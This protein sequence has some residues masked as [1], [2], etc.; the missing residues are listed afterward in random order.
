MICPDHKL[1][2]QIFYYFTICV[3]LHSTFLYFFNLPISQCTTLTIKVDRYL[4]YRQSAQSK[5]FGIIL[6]VNLLHGDSRILIQFQFKGIQR[7][8]ST[9]HH[10]HPST[11]STYFNIYIETQQAEYDIEYLL[12]M[13]FVFRIITLWYSFFL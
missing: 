10:I 3:F 5:T 8:F 12:I 6:Q 13:T 1:P 2:G 4:H 11:R 9:K 7:S